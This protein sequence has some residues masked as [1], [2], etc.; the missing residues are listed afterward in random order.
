M[1]DKIIKCIDCNQDFAWTA[2]EQEFYE[3]KN[4]K[5]PTRCPICRATYKAA[6]KDRFRGKV[7]DRV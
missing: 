2:N 7:K 5:P 6:R 1:K 4:L 3:E